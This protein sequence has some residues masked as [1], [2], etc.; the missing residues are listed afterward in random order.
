MKR[1][2]LSSFSFIVA[3]SFVSLY[4][5]ELTERKQLEYNGQDVMFIAPHIH[6]ILYTYSNENENPLHLSICAAVNTCNYDAVHAFKNVSDQQVKDTVFVYVPLHVAYQLKNNEVTTVTYRPMYAD[7]S[8]GDIPLKVKCVD[9]FE[10]SVKEKIA[11]FHCDFFSQNFGPMCHQYLVR[12]FRK[13]FKNLAQQDI[14]QLL[15]GNINDILE[16]NEKIENAYVENKYTW[17]KN[18]FISKEHFLMRLMYYNLTPETKKC[19]EKS[20][21]LLCWIHQLEKIK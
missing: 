13:P 17:G 14:I 9:G 1:F 4:S 20:L 16:D 8:Y 21:L 15:S 5:M 2:L 19:W 7:G 3:I 11:S 6:P 18:G 10:Q 12:Y